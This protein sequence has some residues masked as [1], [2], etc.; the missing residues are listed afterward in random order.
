MSP[1]FQLLKGA[2]VALA[3]EEK[4][5]IRA[6]QFTQK[7][8]RAPHLVVV[9]VGDDPA[10]QVYV[11]K[12]HEACLRVGF[13]STKIE[14]PLSTSQ[15]DLIQRIRKLNEDETVDGILVQM[16]LP[17]QISTYKIIEMI[18]PLKDVDGLCEANLGSLLSGHAKA[19]SC[20]PKGVMDLLDYYKI[21]IA[22]RHAVVIGRSLIVGKPMSLLLQ[23]RDATV[24][25]CH[26][27]T[28][29]LREHTQ[30]ADI[31]IVAAGKAQ[32]FGADYFKAGAVVIDVGIHRNEEGKV[33]GDVRLQELKQKVRAASPVPGGVGMMTI[34]AL[35]ENL[36]GLAEARVGKK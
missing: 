35:L 21:E 13:L 25:M 28:Q 10:S 7:H 3:I 23:A 1:D 16:P 22:G 12:K 19:V 6:Q 26:S 29:N 31:V 27:K 30:L 8:N 20:T 33:V 11:T 34:A 36:M 2:P 5:K 15:G 9:L 17:P 4:L 32:S 24:T 14:L 18:Q